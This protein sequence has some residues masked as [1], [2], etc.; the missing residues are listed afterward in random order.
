[1]AAT[2]RVAWT[3]LQGAVLLA[4]AGCVVVH[5]ALLLPAPSPLGLAMLA[6]AAGCLLCLRPRRTAP[7]DA[8]WGGALAM[9][10]GML[11]LHVAS[12]GSGIGGHRHPAP[13]STASGLDALHGAA[14]T[15]GSTELALLM[16][17]AVAIGIARR[18]RLVR[19]FADSATGSVN[20]D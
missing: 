20:V 9:S 12:S 19:S 1:M 18:R 16:T 14:L 3:G 10:A 7:P 15:L 5:L 6:L 11:L 4:S 17:A 2:T 13:P 8:A